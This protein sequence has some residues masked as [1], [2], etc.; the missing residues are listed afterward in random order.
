MKETNPYQNV[1]YR[2]QDEQEQAKLVNS[3]RFRSPSGNKYKKWSPE[4]STEERFA[5]KRQREDKYIKGLHKADKPI[6]LIKDKHVYKNLKD[7]EIQQGKGQTND[8][9]FKISK[10]TQV[11]D[12]I[13]DAI[14]ANTPGIRKNTKVHNVSKPEIN[15]FSL[16][17]IYKING[18]EFLPE[19]FLELEPLMY[20]DEFEFESKFHEGL[21]EDEQRKMRSLRRK[22]Y[23][24][25]EHKKKRDVT[26]FIVDEY[27]DHLTEYLE[28]W[29]AQNGRRLTAEEIDHIAKIINT[30]SQSISRLQEVYLEKKKLEN[31]TKLA[32]YLTTDDKLRDERIS[33]LP[34]HIKKHFLVGEEIYELNSKKSEDLIRK[35]KLSNLNENDQNQLKD[36]RSSSTSGQI[37]NNSASGAI[38][39]PHISVTIQDDSN[40]LKPRITNE[41]LDHSESKS[42][43]KSK[44]NEKIRIN[45]S[46]N[47]KKSNDANKNSSS[48]RKPEIEVDRLSISNRKPEIE[49]D[50]LSSLN[51]RN[52]SPLNSLNN[53][54]NP[55]KSM[56]NGNRVSNY[57]QNSYLERHNSKTPQKKSSD[58]PTFNDDKS[59]RTSE[60]RNNNNSVNSNKFDQ[61][62]H[63]KETHHE[64]K[65]RNSLSKTPHYND[66]KSDSQLFQKQKTQNSITEINKKKNSLSFI[67]DS[68]VGKG[69]NT[70]DNKDINIYYDEEINTILDRIRE[71]DYNSEKKL[72]KLP[73][74]VKVKNTEPT[75]EL[76]SSINKNSKYSTQA[77]GKV[78]KNDDYSPPSDNKFA[79]TD[80]RSN[81]KID[82]NFIDNLTREVLSNNKAYSSS[83]NQ[84]ESRLTSDSK[85]PSNYQKVLNENSISNRNSKS[86]SNPMQ[87]RM[88]SQLAEY[89]KNPFEYKRQAEAELN[90]NQ[91]AR[92]SFQ[93]QQYNEDPFN[94]KARGV[95]FLDPSYHE[96]ER[97]LNLKDE[98]RPNSI[99][100]FKLGNRDSSPSLK[101]TKEQ[102]VNKTDSQHL[103]HLMEITNHAASIYSL[104]PDTKR[105][106]IVSLSHNGDTLVCQK[107]RPSLIHNQYYS[108]IIDD[109]KELNGERKSFVTVKN[110]AGDIVDQHLIN[111][112]QLGSFHHSVVVQDGRKTSLLLRNEKGTTLAITEIP[113]D[114]TEVKDKSKS[115]KGVYG[116]SGERRSTISINNNSNNEM[117]KEFK[118]PPLAV[119]NEYYRQSVIH[120]RVSGTDRLSVITKNENG[121]EI[122]N[123]KVLPKY[124][125]ENYIS[126]VTEEKNEDAGIRRTV[127]ST[128]NNRG[129]VVLKQS[130]GMKVDSLLDEYKAKSLL[131]EV[132]NENGSRKLTLIE[133]KSKRFSQF[134]STVIGDQYYLEIVEEGID[135]Y[136]RNKT[137]ILTRKINPESNSIIRRTEPI[138]TSKLA[139]EHLA[140]IERKLFS[141]LE[142]NLTNKDSVLIRPLISDYIIQIADENLK[143]QSISVNVSDARGNSLPPQVYKLSS[144]SIAAKKAS[145]NHILNDVEDK[146]EE[147]KRNFFS[148]N[149][150]IDKRLSLTEKIGRNSTIKNKSLS[151]S[152]TGNKQSLVDNSEEKDLQANKRAS[153]LEKKTEIDESQIQDE[154]YRDLLENIL[155]RKFSKGSAGNPRQTSPSIKHKTK[156]SEGK[157]ADLKNKNSSTKEELTTHVSKSRNSS[158]TQTADLKSNSNKNRV[159]LNQFKK[160]SLIEKIYS[161]NN[162]RSNSIGSNSQNQN[163]SIK[164]SHPHPNRESL[165]QNSKNSQTTSKISDN[166]IFFNNHQSNSNKSNNRSSKANND[167]LSEAKNESKSDLVSN[168][169]ASKLSN[170]HNLMKEHSKPSLGHVK[171]STQIS[172]SQN[173]DYNP[174]IKKSNDYVKKH[175]DS[176]DPGVSLDSQTKLLIDKSEALKGYLDDYISTLS[177]SN[178][179]NN[180]YN[181]SGSSLH[182]NHK[183]EKSLKDKESLLPET[184]PSTSI[185]QDAQLREKIMEVFDQEKDKL[186]EEMLQRVKEKIHEESYSS[187]G[188]LDEFYEFCKIQLPN[189][190]NYKDSMVL[191]S[192]F[193]YFLEKKNLIK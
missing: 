80:R 71:T 34:D 173:L 181:T 135:E 103:N 96:I 60:A 25:K 128:I 32:E 99:F 145:L 52:K 101:K 2:P 113:N 48:N 63:K 39:K 124:I 186:G 13:D 163:A 45:G 44:I 10:N 54:Q 169:S 180:N 104:A 136:G 61:I 125:A 168:N 155:N 14:Q 177:K 85:S 138:D 93:L 15:P 91:I 176:F 151:N 92:M 78:L 22:Q 74:E 191:V 105:I 89:E 5:R 67:N 11:I 141:E 126:C 4:I 142:K 172:V 165:N 12:N 3:F 90:N 127:V 167:D 178:N 112:E 102:I 158:L 133:N 131:E 175:D 100:D 183:I 56:N 59:N 193:Y 95:S 164:S 23:T 147:S 130:F 62:K 154:Y 49:V 83:K 144:N 33:L 159:V 9:Y 70:N 120:S 69:N 26:I 174:Y 8:D 53:K 64:S 162:S 43:Q 36:K 143:N 31:A 50:R 86:E 132:E 179:R 29:Y 166:N 30:E 148:R 27:K 97:I 119:G 76:S 82:S 188:L 6:L 87:M 1:I 73:K 187:R 51:D 150:Q 149:S 88:S 16:N 122:S 35:K 42:S 19:G 41:R 170:A 79:T 160:S 146:F 94:Y 72:S 68:R 106:T 185:A 38:S 18:I 98:D 77:V 192:L 46:I 55:N 140:E 189:D 84:K 182:Q 107:L 118:L 81:S 111:P 37:R 129:E 109:I 24:Q 161:Q 57:S 139:L 137:S 110:E 171:T 123:I 156:T 65:S 28:E 114:Q 115:I 134:R 117:T 190:S 47:D 121:E 153:K 17:S 7:T 40:H 66:E 108:Q 58:I 21:F 116:P 152:I 20:K 75:R 157:E 184:Q